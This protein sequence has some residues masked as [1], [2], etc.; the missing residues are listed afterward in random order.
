MHIP[1]RE[2]NRNPLFVKSQ[3]YF[4]KHVK[5]NSPVIGAITPGAYCKIHRTICRFRYD[6]H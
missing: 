5:I 2:W 6:N 1:L 4:F 3:F